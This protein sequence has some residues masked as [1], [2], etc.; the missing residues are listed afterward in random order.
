MPAMWCLYDFVT[1]GLRIEYGVPFIYQ[2]EIARLFHFLGVD[3]QG[4]SALKNSVLTGK[5]CA[6]SVLGSR[7]FGVS[8][9]PRAQELAPLTSLQTPFDSVEN[10]QQYVRLLVE[11]IAEAKNEISADLDLAAK[12]KLERRVQAM[13]IVQ[14]KL[15]KLEQHLKTSSRLL[16]D[17]RSLRRLL[18]EERPLD[19]RPLDDQSEPDPV[20]P[21]RDSA[22]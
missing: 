8:H 14:F 17:L 19:D 10:A 2:R 12:A 9:F 3:L 6:C 4:R 5:C 22:A 1:V 11:T 15:D 7:A 16:N 18:L 20:S 13:Q 21:D